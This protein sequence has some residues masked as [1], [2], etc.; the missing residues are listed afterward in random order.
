MRWNWD[1]MQAKFKT[2]KAPV[3][4]VN[5]VAPKELNAGESTVDR[6]Q[7]PKFKMHVGSK[8]R[9]MVLYESVIN[10]NHM[11]QNV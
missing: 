5:A 11:V 8:V 6:L 10:N 3:F 2:R 9:T 7:M 1:Q 4:G